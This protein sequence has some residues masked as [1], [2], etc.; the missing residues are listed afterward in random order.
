MGARLAHAALY[1]AD[2]EGCKA[3]Y[4]TYFGAA[5][6]DGYHNPKTGLRTHF[7]T[8]AGDACL[9]LMQR[10]AMADRASGEYP[11]GY[12]HIAFQLEGR[13]AVDALTARLCAD[14][15]AVLSGP[16]VTGDGYYESCIA[17]PEGNP[18]ELV[19]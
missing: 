14:G 11:L 16:R 12:A 6:N 10:P 1:V 9:E 13:E 8:F 15:Y 17:D 5:S 7:L 18:V 3:F 2:L 19:G 4:Q